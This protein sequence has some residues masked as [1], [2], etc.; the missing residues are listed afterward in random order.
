MHN[1]E[2]PF[3]GVSTAAAVVMKEDFNAD[4]IT[5]DTLHCGL[6]DFEAGSYN[7]SVYMD[8]DKRGSSRY[9][10]AGLSTVYDEDG[11]WDA[12]LL[13]YDSRGVLHELQYYPR[14][15]SISPAHGSLEGGTEITI[16]GGGFSMD[17]SVND[18]LV[19]GKACAITYS[20]LEVIRC[21][22]SA[23]GNETRTAKSEESKILST[24]DYTDVDLEELFE[25]GAAR[26]GCLQ[27][28]WWE[29]G[30]SNSSSSS[31]SSGLDFY[32][33]KAPMPSR[34]RPG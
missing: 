3:A 29:I 33:D 4:P 12:H 26:L 5:K 13:S 17:E 31:S 21:N 7:V 27:S 24:V 32:S 18:V 28:M 25:K 9:Y 6:G 2:A 34:G 16:N 30:R 10:V 8:N 14:I 20:T 22:T 15:D 11:Y 23:Y 1:P 19:D